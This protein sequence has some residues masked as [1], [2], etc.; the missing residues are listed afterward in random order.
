MY[1]LPVKLRPEL[2]C[3]AISHKT[4]FMIQAAREQVGLTANNGQA[5]NSVPEDSLHAS[6]W[7]GQKHSGDREEAAV[8]VVRQREGL[9][10]SS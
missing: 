3:K 5:Y 8:L 10:M 7:P 6:V 1:E 2:P 4:R 9:R